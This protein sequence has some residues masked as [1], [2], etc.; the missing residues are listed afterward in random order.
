M[1]HRRF[2]LFGTMGVVAIVAVLVITN[3]S[4]DLTYYLYPS[5]VA[6]QRPDLPDG[7]RFRLAGAV[8]QGSITESGPTTSFDVTDGGATIGVDLTG[9]VPPLFG[10]GVPVLV[11]GT[12]QGDRFASDLAIIRHDE[13]Y[14]APAEGGG[15]A[16]P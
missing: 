12:L 16:A 14:D 15:F 11:E 2:V 1:D 6:T 3:L 7:R 9:R 4:S 13:N 10:E 5:E 8:V